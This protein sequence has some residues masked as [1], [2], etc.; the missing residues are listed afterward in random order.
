[1]KDNNQFLATPLS[2]RLK[3]QDLRGERQR[4][5]HG[6]ASDHSAMGRDSLVKDDNQCVATPLSHRLKG[7]DLESERQ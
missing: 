4:S 6:N 1:M 2:N 5:V 3:R 7:Q